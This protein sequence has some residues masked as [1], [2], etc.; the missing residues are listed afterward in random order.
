MFVPLPNGTQV[1]GDPASVA[2][3]FAPLDQDAF[4]E[5]AAIMEFDAGLDRPEA[6]RL[7]AIQ[8][9]QEAGLTS[10]ETSTDPIMNAPQSETT[11]TT[12]MTLPEEATT[13][14]ERC[15]TDP[16]APLESNALAYLDEMKRKEPA[17]YSRTHQ[18]LKDAGVSMALLADA[19]KQTQGCDRDGGDLQGTRIQWPAVE[20]WPDR[21]SGE[22]LLDE[23]SNNICRHV[24]LQ[25]AMADAIALWCLTTWIHDGLEISTFLNVTSATKR[26]G[27]SLL[28]EIL[29]E[30]IHRP[31][32]ASGRVTSAVL[33][34]TIEDH[35][36]T[37]LLD[38]ADTYFADN[39]ELRGVVN[40]SQRR[41]M[42][43]ILRC[44]GDHHEPRRFETWCPKV[45][46]GIGGLH[47]TVVD[48]ALVI[49]LERKP[50][51]QSVG[52]WRDRDREA[53]ESLRRRIVRWIVDNKEAILD[54]RNTVI[55]PTDLHD[56]ACDAWEAL[57]A[58]ANIAG[59]DWAGEGGRAWHAS[60][61][62]NTDTENQTGV[63]EKLLADL[64]RVFVK[65]GNPETMPTT[66]IL[67]GLIAMEG[68]PWSEWKHGKPLSPRGLSDLLKPFRVGPRNIRKSG[69]I[70][71]GYK[72]TDLQD[73]WKAY[74]TEKEGYLSAT[75]LQPN[76][77]N[78]LEDLQSATAQP[79]VADTNGPNLLKNNDCSGVAD[80]KPL[81]PKE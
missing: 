25:T 72:R 57:I 45:I 55:F 21:V 36:P 6:E 23:I 74:L 28:M 20:P 26:C 16:G 30:F 47:D 44:V 46:S 58:I 78:G 27:K 56:R 80:T 52:R 15:K 32:Q 48:R 59:G 5:R 79:G 60:D 10:S 76:K 64:H 70:V 24:Y 39:P 50:A 68:R 2:R 73:H 3:P 63:R 31:L 14:I 53:I 42:A 8:M 43:Y 65:A 49:R 9:L 37:L 62:I 29:A 71:K 51:D 40:G 66:K 22:S 81:E 4:E 33:F 69:A 41:N 34:R 19:L 17:T 61:T 75:P 11:N 18:K 77:I 67:I 13:L 38:E 35:A 7:A 54:G 1:D 12:A